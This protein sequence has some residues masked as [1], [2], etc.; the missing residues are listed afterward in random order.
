MAGRSLKSLC[1]SELNSRRDRGILSPVHSPQGCRPDCRRRHHDGGVDR[2]TREGLGP[3]G[4]SVSAKEGTATTRAKE[5][6]RN[7]PRWP[8]RQ[9]WRRPIGNVRRLAGRR[10]QVARL[11]PHR[12]MLNAAFGGQFASRLNLSLREQKGYSYRAHSSFEWRVHQAGPFTAAA[13]VRT[14]VTAPAITE[15]L[16][17]LNGMAGDQP[18]TPKELEFCQKV[19]LARLSVRLRDRQQIAT[20]L[21]TVATYHLP[22]DYFNTVVPAIEK[23]TCAD[24]SR[25]AKKYFR[26]GSC[27]WWWWAIGR[28]S[29]PSCANCP[30]ASRC[31]SSSSTTI[32]VWCRPN[33]RVIVGQAR[34][35]LTE[36][37]DLGATAGLSSSA[38][39]VAPI[40]CLSGCR[41]HKRASRHA[42]DLLRLRCPDRQAIGATRGR[43]LPKIPNPH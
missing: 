13:A 21:Q 4:K 2:A 17:E 32:S 40:A 8:R 24:V 15:F 42:R 35:C 27:S 18:V 3:A 5:R 11:F 38:A 12:T 7:G 36:S 37:G 16:K 20:Q 34:G 25:M 23:V 31:K 6:S 10:S 19:L 41:R 22:D 14:E 26:P 1:P 33:R 39:R 9:A 29:S 30:S 28:R 43:D